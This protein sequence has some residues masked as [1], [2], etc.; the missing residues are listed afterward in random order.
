MQRFM[1]SFTN[2]LNSKHD[3]S[4]TFVIYTPTSLFFCIL[5]E[6][7]NI[8]SKRHFNNEYITKNIQINAKL[9]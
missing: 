1:K 8:K 7:K 5:R 4:I 2:D 6:T 3:T 9:L